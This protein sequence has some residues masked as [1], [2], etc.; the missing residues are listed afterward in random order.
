MARKPMVTRTIISTEVN[1]LCLD[2]TTQEPFNEKVIISGIIKDD[3][4]LFKRVVD[5]VETE[6]VK[7]VHIVDKVEIEKLYGM[8]EEDFIKNA[9]ELNPETRKPYAETTE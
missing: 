6:T 2:L 5:F 3:K 1:I 9:I 8:S 7:P 4:K